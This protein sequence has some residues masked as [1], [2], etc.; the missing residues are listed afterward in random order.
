MVVADE[1]RRVESVARGVT[2]I[3]SAQTKTSEKLMTVPE[4]LEALG[5]EVS[6][7]TFYKWRT[8]GKGPTCFS[9]PNGDLRCRETEFVAWVA[10]L[11]NGEL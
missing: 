9:L 3:K 6:K 4:M 1:V 5:G 10:K 2:D 11:E 8:K 7:H